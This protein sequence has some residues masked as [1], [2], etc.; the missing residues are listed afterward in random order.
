MN[1]T[2]YQVK[3]H[4]FASYGENPMYP[5]LGLAEEAGEV[6]GKIAKFIRHNNGMTPQDAEESSSPLMRDEV[7]K[8]RSSLMSE[9]SDV[10][11]M[12]AEL[13]TN[14]GLDMGEVMAEN[15]EKLAD[16]KDKGLIIGEG[17]TNEERIANAMSGKKKMGSTA[18]IMDSNRE[19][20]RLVGDIEVIIGE[21]GDR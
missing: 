19:A 17:D 12:V 20:M 9:L 7:A 5:A 4:D 10:M 15:I 8:F 13:C 2:E 1:A 6:C 21:E 14:Y 11:W 16:R 3:A 18:K